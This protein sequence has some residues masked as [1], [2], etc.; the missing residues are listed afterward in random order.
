MQPLVPRPSPLIW[1]AALLLLLL[2][3]AAG[4]VILDLA[5]GLLVVVVALPLILGGLGWLG[6]RLIQSR[7]VACP[8]CGA[9]SLSANG[10]CSLCGADL[11]AAAGS[12]S[13]APASSMTI[14]VKAEN[15][16]R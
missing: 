1:I 14:D 16:D 6:W 2:P 3:T 10:R 9:M 5:G 4:R 13:S 7:M 8:A 15:V 12:A 11:D